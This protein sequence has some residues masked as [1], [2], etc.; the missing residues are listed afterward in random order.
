[1]A[2][3]T[4]AQIVIPVWLKDLR[5]TFETAPGASG[6]QALLM[7]LALQYDQTVAMVQQLSDDAFVLRGLKSFAADLRASYAR[8]KYL[9]RRYLEIVESND[10]LALKLVNVRNY[11]A[12]P[13]LDGRYPADM[14]AALNPEDRRGIIMQ[15]GGG[16]RGFGDAVFSAT[17]WNQAAVVGDFDA[18]LGGDWATNAMRELF[19]TV[20]M[21]LEESAPGDDPTLRDVTIDTLRK[22]ADAPGALL[23]AVGAGNLLVYVGV[24]VGLGLV[25]WL[26][27]R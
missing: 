25:V 11:I 21:N 19:S 2:R 10:P 5:A 9:A 16:G 27:S 23:K 12:G 8:T 22:V 6:S 14:M 1:M 15:P 13:I 20:A 17:L 4:T 18:K 3:E 26:A 24:G 7:L